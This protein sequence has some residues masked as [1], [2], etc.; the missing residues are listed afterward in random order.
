MKI[1]TIRILSFLFNVSCLWVFPVFLRIAAKFNNTVPKPSSL[2]VHGKKLFIHPKQD[3]LSSSL[4]YYGKYEPF[5]TS[6]FQSLIKK[7]NIVV[8]IGAHIGYYSLLAS[9][10]VGK[11]GKVFAF[12]PDPGNIRLLRQN[13]TSNKLTNVRV[14]GKAATNTNK[15]FK[16]YISGDNKGDNR[17]FPYNQADK[18]ISVKGITLDSYFPIS[19]N[20]IDL[21]KIDVQG[22]E[23][24]VLQ[25][26]SKVLKT[27]PHIILM[28]E[29]WPY[30]FAQNGTS[31][32]QLLDLL[33]FNHFLLYN[34]G[35]NEA[36][37]TLKSVT[38]NFLLSH[39]NPKNLK[40]M[41]NILCAH[42]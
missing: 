11:T 25:G 31:A 20:R 35:R 1:R 33:C 3:T 27:N 5:E 12:E 42:S 36:R 6:L 38:A 41:T 9:N 39:Y 40:A 32:K 7:G 21:V 17:L 29:F 37:Q 22:G 30:G 13:I 34:L 16:F 14:I 4:Y 26:M 19:R 2:T 28:L 23:V 10:L 15:W 8:D 24:K 18:C